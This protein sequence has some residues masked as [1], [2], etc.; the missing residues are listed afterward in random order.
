MANVKKKAKAKAVILNLLVVV[1]AVILLLVSFTKNQQSDLKQFKIASG[2][3]TL[4]V[5]KKYEAAYVRMDDNFRLVN[6]LSGFTENVQKFLDGAEVIKK[7]NNKNL[8][9]NDTYLSFDSELL[10]DKGTKKCSFI[11]SKNAAL[12]LDLRFSTQQ[13]Q[14]QG[15][16]KKLPRTKKLPKTENEI[17][18][19]DL[20]SDYFKL[21]FG[22]YGYNK[23]TNAINLP[24]YMETGKKHFN[25]CTFTN[26][27]KPVYILNEKKSQENIKKGKKE[28]ALDFNIIEETLKWCQM[29]N[30]QMRGH[31]LVWHT[32]TPLWFFCED[33]DATKD[34]VTREEMINR[35]D[36]FTKQYMNYVQQNFPGVVYCWDIVNEAVDPSKGDN[37]TDFMCRMENDNIENYWYY[38]IGKDYPEVA[39]TIARKY[40]AEGVKLFY[41][42][43]GTVDR[44]KREYIYTLCKNLKE[45]GLIDGIGMQGYWDVK[46]PPLSEIKDAIELYAS[47]G[48]EIQLTEWSIPARE[49]TEN[50]YKEQAERYA[51]VFR[52]LKTLDTDGGGTANITSVTFFG[53]MDG[54]TLYGNDKTNTRLF[55]KNLQPKPAFYSI[56]DTFE[57]WY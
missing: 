52:L 5:E 11:F 43:Y 49:N 30:V 44:K 45:K 9:E 46:N 17:G 3:C 40:A 54:Y 38:T 22:I 1:V 53:I 26:L 57:T 14:S 35:L 29:N 24:K 48:I 34:Y 51:S 32:Q 50:G 25:S 7:I 28:P 31:T 33:Y 10:T 41:N 27:M 12:P 18:L 21:G 47:L 37:S 8:A 55:D 16:L 2:I 6:S 20:C 4:L 39:F 23:Q 56:R 19:K 15:V 36:S 42:D 13:A